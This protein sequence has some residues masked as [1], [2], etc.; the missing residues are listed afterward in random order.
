M[1][2]A[3]V[4]DM[5]CA[6]TGFSDRLR[7]LTFGYTLAKLDKLPLY[8]V[9]WM[10]NSHCPYELP[11]DL[12]KDFT[13]LTNIPENIDTLLFDLC[14]FS[15]LNYKFC[16][17][18]IKNHSHFYFCKQWRKSYSYIN[19]NKYCNF[20]L[21]KNTIGIHLRG[22]DYFYFK[23]Y[24]KNILKFAF[25]AIEIYLRLFKP[26]NVFFATDDEKSALKFKEIVEN[27]GGNF[28]KHSH[29]FDTK[30]F[31]QTTLEALLFDICCLSQCKFILSNTFSGVAEMAANISRSSL[32]VVSLLHPRFLIFAIWFYMRKRFRFAM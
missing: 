17:R 15:P 10:I 9:N 3:I 21:P 28:I 31:R 26:K 22:T 32:R 5:S 30:K 25:F 16:R 13:I 12:F 24:F 14:P 8:V 7:L 29:S 1:Y 6:K 20:S 27:Y 11:L 18:F 4:I 23:L 19:L 2:S